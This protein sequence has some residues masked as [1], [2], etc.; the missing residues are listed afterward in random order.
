[1]KQAR[2]AEATVIVRAAL[3]VRAVKNTRT[4][5]P[6]AARTIGVR[7]Q[8]AQ[9]VGKTRTRW[10]K[11]AAE[12]A[13]DG[14]W[15][16][17]VPM[18]TTV[19]AGDVMRRVCPGVPAPSATRAQNVSPTTAAMAGAPRAAAGGPATTTSIASRTTA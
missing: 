10:R 9:T 18:G 17:P 4:A 15:A 2:I 13:T 1:M 12:S 16:R 3:Q 5:P 14:P 19:A 8:L 6:T 11:T 7:S